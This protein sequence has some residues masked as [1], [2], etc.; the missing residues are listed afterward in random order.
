MEVKEQVAPGGRA[1]GA[2]GGGQVGA[3]VWAA[4]RELV[5]AGVRACRVAVWEAGGLQTVWQVKRGTRGG[6][7]PAFSA[8]VLAVSCSIAVLTLPNAVNHLHPPSSR[9]PPCAA[10]SP[11]HELAQPRHQ[12]F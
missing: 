9:P 8:P 6:A 4:G 2:A 3:A 1:R 12:L 11:R 5:V 7:A 10:C